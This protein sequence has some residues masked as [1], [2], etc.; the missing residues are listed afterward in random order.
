LLQSSL[1]LEI[2]NIVVPC[3]KVE[4]DLQKPDDFEELRNLDVKETE[5]SR[6]IHNTIPGHIGSSYNH[7]MTLW[8]CNIGCAENPKIASIRE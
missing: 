2:D 6:E 1:S 4:K 8:K 7:P 3:Y 5:G